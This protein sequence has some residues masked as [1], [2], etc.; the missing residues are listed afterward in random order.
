MNGFDKD[1]KE[2]ADILKSVD[3]S[4]QSVRHKKE[5]WQTISASRQLPDDELG[6]VAGGQDL[7]QEPDKTK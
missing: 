5:L 1:E 2:I 4:K 3:F 7:P 6:M